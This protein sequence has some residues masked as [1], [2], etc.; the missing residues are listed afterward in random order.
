MDAIIQIEPVSPG[1]DPGVQ[2]VLSASS[3]MA[4]DT[5]P[6]STI[7]LAALSPRADAMGTPT[8]VVG[9]AAVERYGI[10]GLLR[11]VAVHPDQRG[12][13][14]GHY[15]VE[16]AEEESLDAGIKRLYLLTET[17]D[18][19]FDKLGYVRIDRTEVPV[20]VLASDQFSKLCP[21]SAIA[22]YRDLTETD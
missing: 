17:A 2:V 19:F 3:L 12:Q 22:M 6:A 16:A 7:A 9:C 14:L 10:D 5:T 13:N 21:S 8:E 20:D 11:S 1:T 4:L 15:L 18:S